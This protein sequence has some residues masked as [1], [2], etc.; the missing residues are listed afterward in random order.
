MTQE[1]TRRVAELAGTVSG[2]T[3]DIHETTAGQIV[4]DV[5]VRYGGVG[6]RGVGIESDSDSKGSDTRKE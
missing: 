4:R 3:P 1:A 5:S 6:G 2:Y